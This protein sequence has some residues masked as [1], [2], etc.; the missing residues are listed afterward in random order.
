KAEY[1]WN[2]N[3]FDKINATETDYLLGLFSYDHLDYVMDM[4]DTKDPTLPE[5]AKKAIE[6]LSKNPKG[7]FLFIE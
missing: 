6:I 3:Q 7:Y 2:K 5:M 1:V 4:D